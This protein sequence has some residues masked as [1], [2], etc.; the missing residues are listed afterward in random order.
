MLNSTRVA[1]LALAG[2]YRAKI[3][4]NFPTFKLE[5]RRTLSATRPFSMAGQDAAPPKPKSAKE[6]E[7][8]AEPQQPKAGAKKEKAPAV[9]LPP[10]KDDTTPGEKKLLRPFDDPHFS[11]YSPKA[12]ESAWCMFHI[13]RS[14]LGLLPGSRKRRALTWTRSVVGEAGLLQ[15][16]AWQERK[17]RYSPSA[18]ER[19]RCVALRA[20]SGQQL[21]GHAYSMVP[22]AVSAIASIAR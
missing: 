1:A 9:E 10:F 2:L 16:Q 13:S 3:S 7:Q 8:A 15:A 11:A 19:D 12:V 20:R 4:P 21:A 5:S 17:I 22:H 18:A 6:G 14:P